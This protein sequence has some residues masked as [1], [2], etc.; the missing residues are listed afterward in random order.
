MSGVKA[1]ITIGRKHRILALGTAIY[2]GFLCTSVVRADDTNDLHEQIRQLQNQNGQLQDQLL[3]QEQ[4]IENLNRRLSDIEGS[5]QKRSDEIG[6]L[7]EEVEQ[8][9]S[10][11]PASTRPFSS[12]KVVLSGEGGMAF[13]E[14]GSE[15][16]SPRRQRRRSN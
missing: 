14:S 7:K 10:V 13:F 11:P 12:G 8:Q 16:Q 15:K 4:L 2:T 5:N 6:A 1:T 3:K 9:P